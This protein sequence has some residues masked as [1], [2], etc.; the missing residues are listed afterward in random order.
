M[1]KT[2]EYILTHY[3]HEVYF[4][5]PTGIRR[6]EIPKRSLRAKR[7]QVAIENATHSGIFVGKYRTIKRTLCSEVITNR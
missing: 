5:R 1:E 7:L 2:I 6:Y 3:G 4:Y